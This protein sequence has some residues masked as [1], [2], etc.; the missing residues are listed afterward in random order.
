MT[1]PAAGAEDGPA[2]AEARAERAE[3][4]LARLRAAVL[5]LWLCRLRVRV[6]PSAERRCEFWFLDEPCRISRSWKAPGLDV[7][8]KAGVDAS[9]EAHSAVLEAAVRRC[10]RC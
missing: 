4:E 9:D 3:G 10:C 2:A 7:W 6:R 1:R 8:V 5:R